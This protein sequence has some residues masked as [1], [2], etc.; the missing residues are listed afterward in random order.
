M[1]IPALKVVSYLGPTGGAAANDHDE[2]SKYTVWS[3]DQATVSAQTRDQSHPASRAH[4]KA[5]DL[6]TTCL[7][8]QAR[9]MKKIL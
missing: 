9:T 6:R 5:C 8:P 1:A 3:V 7:V 2:A 4:S